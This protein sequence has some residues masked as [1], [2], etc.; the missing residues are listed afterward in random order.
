MSMLR[1]GK[2]TQQKREPIA[3]NKVLKF[4]DNRMRCSLKTYFWTQ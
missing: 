2:K 4:P 3:A 1:N